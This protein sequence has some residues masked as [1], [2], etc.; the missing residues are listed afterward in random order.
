MCIEEGFFELIQVAIGTR[1]SL[2]VAPSANQWSE[3]FA[4]SKKHALTAIAFAGVKRL[5][6]TPFLLKC[7]MP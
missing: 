5:K 6:G 7:F 2:F 1:Q 3:L 4:L